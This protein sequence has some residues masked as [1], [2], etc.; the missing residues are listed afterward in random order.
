MLHFALRAWRWRYLLGPVGEAPYRR[1]LA[2]VLAGYAV[3]NVL[4]ARA[5]EVARAVLLSRRTGLPAAGVFGTVVL[6]RFLDAAMVL[7]LFLLSLPFVLPRLADEVGAAALRQALTVLG[8]LA[9]LG[10]AAGL[11]VLVLVRRDSPV[12]R[13]LLRLVPARFRE[14]V[15]ETVRSFLTG[16]A[17][18]ARARLLAPIAVSSLVVWLDIAIATYFGVV[19]FDV[20][21]SISGS[22]FLMGWLALGIAVP[23]PAGMGGYHK[24]GQFAL[25]SAFGFSLELA[26]GIALVMHAVSVVPVTLVGLGTLL[27]EGVGIRELKARADAPS[28]TLGPAGNG[29]GPAGS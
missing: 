3:N 12:A 8:V 29:A 6:E 9:A 16:F 1:R 14:R 17:S 5:G 18:L 22:L 7:L 11:F 28:G 25:H 10:L 23:T 26:A 27:W 24:A 13:A 2:A 15:R 20:P 19:A 4:P 21:F